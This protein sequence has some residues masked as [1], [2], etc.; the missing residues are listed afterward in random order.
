[1]TTSCFWASKRPE[2][3][4]LLHRSIIWLLLGFILHHFSFILPIFAYPPAPHH[5]F[6]GMVRDE[7]GSPIA[8]GAEVI[9][10]TLSGVQIKTTV[11]PNLEPGVNY[12]LAVPMDSG[13]ASDLY[14]PTALRPTVPFRIR[15]QLGGV[16]YLPIEMTGNLSGMGQPGQRTL[17]NL[18]LGEDTNGDGLPDAWQR[19]INSDISKVK[20]GDDYDKDGLTNMQEYLA[21]TYAFDPK[22]G[23]AL[24]ISRLN[25]DKPVLAFTAITGRTYTLLGAADLKAG[26][27][28]LQFKESGQ[29]DTAIMPSYSAET[30]RSMEIEHRQPTNAA[31]MRFFKLMLQ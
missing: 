26:W 17:L 12:R 30:V 18:T 5:L 10:E 28:T 2:G 29:A 11:I 8:A 19:L 1:M 24:K 25:G 31:P 7:F 21:G 27:T 16:I 13:I 9:L 22:D 4:A 14:K 20:P 23:F 6:Y 15:V 3:I